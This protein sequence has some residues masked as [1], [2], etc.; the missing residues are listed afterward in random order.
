MYCPIGWHFPVISLDDT[1]ACVVRF[2]APTVWWIIMYIDF[3]H[4]CFCWSCMHHEEDPRETPLGILYACK[5]SIYTSKLLELTIKICKNHLRLSSSVSRSSSDIATRWHKSPEQYGITMYKFSSLAMMTSWVNTCVSNIIALLAPLS[6]AF[7]FI[8]PLI[9]VWSTIVL[10]FFCQLPIHCNAAISLI[11]SSLNRCA[12]HARIQFHD[13]T[14][15]A[16]SSL[17]SVQFHCALCSTRA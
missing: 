5:A 2:Q 3:R 1:Y 6:P 4:Y 10:Y 11:W 8:I 14:L 17:V 13:M 9:L 7:P 12:R 16:T 15:M